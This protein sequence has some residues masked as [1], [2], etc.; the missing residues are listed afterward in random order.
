MLMAFSLEVMRR[1][2]TTN[3]KFNVASGR[4]VTLDLHILDLFG[5]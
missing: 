5:L 4:A 1:V 2:N 3:N